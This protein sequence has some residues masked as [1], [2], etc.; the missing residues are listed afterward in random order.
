M[1]FYK[2]PLDISSFFSESDGKLEQ[3]SELESIDQHLALILTSRPGEH[4]FDSSFGTK[5]S[6][7]DFENIISKTIWEEKFIRYITESIEKYEKRLK[8]I[9]IQVNVRDVIREEVYMQGFSV[10]KKVDIIITGTLVS[11]NKQHGFKHLLYLGPLSR[12]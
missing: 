4:R 9:K 2:L 8:N 11:T 6:E 7:M 5:I 10:K 3:C 1:N 12:D